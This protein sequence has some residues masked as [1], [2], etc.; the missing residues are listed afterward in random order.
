MHGSR[1]GRVHVSLARPGA[2]LVAVAA[3]SRARGPRCAGRDTR[4]RKHTM[5]LGALPRKAMFFDLA[6]G[7]G[8]G[9]DSARSVPCPTA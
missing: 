4:C 1:V 2:R 3:P 8:E 6:E 7:M 5:C 9:S